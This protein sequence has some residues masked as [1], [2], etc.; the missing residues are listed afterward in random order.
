MIIAIFILI[1]YYGNVMINMQSKSN[2]TLDILYICH[3]NLPFL[4]FLYIGSE[5]ISKITM[6]NWYILILFLG[7]STTSSTAPFSLEHSHMLKGISITILQS[8]FQ[9]IK[10]SNIK[11]TKILKIFVWN[12]GTITRD[13]LKKEVLTLKY[14]KNHN[15]N[16]GLSFPSVTNWKHP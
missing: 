15:H 11:I 13:C 8:W 6:C 16:S 12:S 14:N 3:L 9:R 7:K 1:I 10:S 4:Y 5:R 2:N